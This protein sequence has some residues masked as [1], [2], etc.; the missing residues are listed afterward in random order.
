M[1]QEYKV[2]EERLLELLRKEELLTALWS[3]GVDN[4]PWYY[5]SLID[6]LNEVTKS[7]LEEGVDQRYDE[8]SYKNL[9]NEFGQQKV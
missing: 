1:A 3:G 8:L 4:W 7:D 2:S 5:E 9:L 6:Y